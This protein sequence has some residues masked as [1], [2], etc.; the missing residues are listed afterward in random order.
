MIKHI[1]MLAMCLLLLY[2]CRNDACYSILAEDERWQI[3][4]NEMELFA[5][6]KEASKEIP[7][8]K[9]YTGNCVYASASDSVS[10]LVHKDSLSAVSKA[11]ILSYQDEPLVLLLQDL[12]NGT[13]CHSFIYQHDLDTLVHLP[14]CGE[15]LGVSYDDNMIIMDS[16]RYNEGGRYGLVQGYSFDGDKMCEMTTKINEK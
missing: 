6:D 10:V 1:Y 5:F 9:L 8:L 14:S 15:Y 7:L 3:R 11:H 12:S 4:L 16:Y 2:S 13:V